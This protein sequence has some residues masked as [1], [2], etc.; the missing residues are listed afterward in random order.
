MAPSPDDR[1]EMLDLIAKTF[2]QGHGYYGFLDYCQKGYLT[3]SHYDY[4]AT[5]I[6]RLDGMIV[7][8]YG[9]W[10]YSMRIGRAAVRVG[11]IGAVATHQRYRKM[12]LMAQTIPHSLKGMSEL[13]YDMSLLFGI[14]D[15]Y[16]RFG[17]VR[18]WSETN[19]FVQTTQLPQSK[20][21]PG[22]K[23]FTDF[24]RPDLEEL[25]NRAAAGL[26]GTAVRPTY[27]RD[28]PGSDGKA[29]IEGRLWKAGAKPAGYILFKLHDNA[30]ECQEGVGDVKDVLAAVAQLARKANVREVR[31]PNVHHESPLAK[32][33]RAMTCRQE[34]AHSRCGGAM[35][36]T[37]NLGSTLRKMAPE[38]SRRL[39]ASH[40]ANWRGKLAIGIDENRITLDINRTKVTVAAKAATVNS[41]VGDQRVSQLLIG[42]DGPREIF[43]AGGVRARG[44]ASMLADVLFPRQYPNLASWDR[45]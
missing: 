39:A 40:L 9:V 16:H 29:G 44:E 1:Q 15:F 7:T 41:I 13:G 14:S 12:G 22:M 36:R 34:I 19:Y 28:R 2:A 32:A 4:A 21:P 20:P 5:R 11:G 45:F 3:D 23:P 37:M 24:A 6:G 35:I 30:L 42:T 25:Y 8:H 26:T 38:L 17:Y 31:F 33:L 27:H 18:A 10:D 43:E